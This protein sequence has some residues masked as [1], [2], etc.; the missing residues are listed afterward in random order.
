MKDKFPVYLVLGILISIIGVNVY[1]TNQ[2]NDKNAPHYLQ[3]SI[4]FL[5]QKS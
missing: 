5:E 3:A 1:L 4:I 2:K